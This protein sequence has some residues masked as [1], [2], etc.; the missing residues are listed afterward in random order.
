MSKNSTEKEIQ[1]K[2]DSYFPNTEREHKHDSKNEKEINLKSNEQKPVNSTK[3]DLSNIET[4]EFIKNL[5]EDERTNKRKAIDLNFSTDEEENYSIR[6][7]KSKKISK[8]N[9]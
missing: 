9:Y 1:K 2:I 3:T 5:N 4:N 8:V 6:T 7:K